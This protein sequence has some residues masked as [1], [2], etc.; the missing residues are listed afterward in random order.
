[1]RVRQSIP[2]CWL[3]ITIHE[4]RNRQVRRMTAAVGHPTLRLVRWSIG[5][6]TLADIQPGEWR[7]AEQQSEKR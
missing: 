1:I 6:W 2:D 5:D 7:M 3:K 4:G